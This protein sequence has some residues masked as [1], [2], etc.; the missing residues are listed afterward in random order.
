MSLGPAP[1][2]NDCPRKPG[3]AEGRGLPP[4]DVID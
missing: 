2:A 4:A 1:R 3:S